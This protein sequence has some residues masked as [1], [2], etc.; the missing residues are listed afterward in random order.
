MGALQEKAKTRYPSKLFS[1]KVINA[2]LTANIFQKRQGHHK[3]NHLEERGMERSS[4]R[5]SSLKA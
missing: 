2:V 1:T 5:L 3:I 4:A